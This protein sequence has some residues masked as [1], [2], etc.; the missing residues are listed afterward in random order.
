M[1]KTVCLL[2]EVE[3]KVECHS[4]FKWGE[5]SYVPERPQSWCLLGSVEKKNWPHQSLEA[6]E[7]AVIGSRHRTPN[8]YKEGDCQC[9]WSFPIRQVTSTTVPEREEHKQRDPGC[10]TFRCMGANSDNNIWR[11]LI[12]CHLYWR[13]LQAHL[14]LPHEAEEWSVHTLPKTQKRGRK[15]NKTSCQVPSV[16]RGKGVLL[17][18][19]YNLTLKGRNSTRI[20]PST[21]TST[22]RSRRKEKLAHIRGVKGNDER[23]KPTKVVVG[24]SG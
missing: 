13:L 18:W 6:Q 16:G 10:N 15:G 11:M 17:R 9:V 8:F 5:V 20:Y 21:H 23:D 22:K 19:I 14:D 12:L 7:H 1:K 24:R 2:L 3:E 4:W